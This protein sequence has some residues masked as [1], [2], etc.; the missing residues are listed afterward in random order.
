MGLSRGWLHPPTRQTSFWTQGGFIECAL[1]KWRRPLQNRRGHLVVTSKV[2]NMGIDRPVKPSVGRRRS[3]N[4][5]YGLPFQ[6][7]RIARTAMGRGGAV[8]FS[9]LC[10]EEKSSP[11]QQPISKHF[12]C[13]GRS[14][15]LRSGFPAKADDGVLP[16]CS[17]L[18]KSR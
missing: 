1:S 3:R 5:M 12:G 9:F 6:R 10:A 8:P 16:F 13:F 18:A 15:C 2:G 11:F 7:N 4:Y 14:G 17:D